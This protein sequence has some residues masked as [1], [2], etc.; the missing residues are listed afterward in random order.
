MN[1]LRIYL[2]VVSIFVLLVLAVSPFKDYFSE[3]RNYQ[4]S[5]N[6]LIADL[7]QDRA[8]ALLWRVSGKSL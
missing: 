7:P 2:A 4:N 1:R 6:H 8:I 5:Y 3:W